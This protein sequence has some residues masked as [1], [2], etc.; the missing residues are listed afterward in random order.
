M[1]WIIIKEKPLLAIENELNRKMTYAI[2]KRLR[3]DK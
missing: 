3:K 1:I 2:I